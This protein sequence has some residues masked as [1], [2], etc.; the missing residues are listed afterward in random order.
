MVTLFSRPDKKNVTYKPIWILYFKKNLTRLS[1]LWFGLGNPSWPDLRVIWTPLSC[2][3]FWVVT[4]FSRSN[5]KIPTH[6]PTWILCFPKIQPNSVLWFGLGNPSLSYLRVIW[7]PLPCL[8]FWVV[9][10]FL[11]PFANGPE[12][13]IFQKSNPT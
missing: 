8:S 9:T 5:K 6:K 2:L 10:L 11:R 12:F 3:N 4:L 7:T 1:L 13:S